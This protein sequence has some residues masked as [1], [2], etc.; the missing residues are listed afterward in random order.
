[1]NVGVIYEK[2]ADAFGFTPVLVGHVRV[3][4]YIEADKCNDCCVNNK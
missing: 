3:S 1:M 4:F 2:C